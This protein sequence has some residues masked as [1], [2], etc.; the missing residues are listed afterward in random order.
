MARCGGVYAEQ[1]VQE[2]RSNECGSLALGWCRLH[3]LQ[4]IHC[5]G[6]HAE[7]EAEDQFR[8]AVNEI[9]KLART[10]ALVMEERFSSFSAI[11]DFVVERARSSPDRMAL[12]WWG[13][14]AGIASGLVGKLEEASGFLQAVS[15]ERVTN[16]AMSLLPL[17]FDSEAFKE[18]GER[19]RRATASNAEI[20]APGGSGVLRLLSTPNCRSKP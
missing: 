9:A 6:G 18:Q 10:N 14:E 3:E 12:S 11:A 2:L 15:D 17:V 8:S 1:V 4:R 7:F 16:R 13:Y 5:S 20:E 19:N